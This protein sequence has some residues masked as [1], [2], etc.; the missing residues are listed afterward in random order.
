MAVIT[1][2]TPALIPTIIQE[3]VEMLSSECNPVQ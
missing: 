3:E 1:S 2:M